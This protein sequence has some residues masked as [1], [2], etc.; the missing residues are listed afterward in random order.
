[1]Q[2]LPT[3][4][5]TI[6]LSN[7]GVS[8]WSMVNDPKDKPVE[9]EEFDIVSDQV[10]YLTEQITEI[11]SDIEQIKEILKEHSRRLDRLEDDSN[12]K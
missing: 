10:G 2:G 9:R 4:A 8:P 7:V 1:M 5:I 3:I 6:N 12:D 11:A